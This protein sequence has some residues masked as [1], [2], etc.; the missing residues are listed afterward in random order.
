MNILVFD[1]GIGGLTVLEQIQQRLPHSH[2]TYLFD[3]ARLPYGELSEQ[4]LVDGALQL[5]LPV[6]EKV[7]ADII[8]IACNTASTILLPQLRARTSIPVVGVV[9]AIKPA[10]QISITKRIGLLATPAT[11]SRAYTQDL[12][13]QFAAQ[14]FVGLFGSSELVEM[15]EAKMA[16]KPIDLVRLS[17]IIAPIIE[18][19]IDTL[20]L[21]C[22]HFPILAA[23]IKSA[24]G[25]KV[26]L[27]DS[28]LAI[29][30]R[31]VELSGVTESAVERNKA[32]GSMKAFYTTD[33]DEGLRNTLTRWG[34]TT[35]QPY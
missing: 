7:R 23:E 24:L 34:F 25:H 1:S 35:V 18:A 30:A 9:P 31:V 29:A 11:V 19:N 8:V 28:G 33:I 20:V 22:T 26:Q 12:I 14:C 10:A 6:S 17:Q 2:Y 15:A 27:L 5:I 32:T 3:N 21:G 13:D 4:T 16:G